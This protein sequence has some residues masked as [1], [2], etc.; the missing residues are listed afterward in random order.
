MIY[1]QIIPTI[2]LIRKQLSAPLKWPGSRQR[3]SAAQEAISHYVFYGL[4]VA[5][6]TD[7]LSM[8][9]RDRLVWLLFFFLTESDDLVVLVPHNGTIDWFSVKLECLGLF[10]SEYFEIKAIGVIYSQNVFSLDFYSDGNQSILSREVFLIFLWLLF[11]ISGTVF[12]N[13]LF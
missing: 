13:I 6:A 11:E 7:A 8:H 4:S 12:S 2:E 5:P 3:P 9:G 10:D 1:F